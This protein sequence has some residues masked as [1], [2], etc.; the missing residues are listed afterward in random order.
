MKLTTADDAGGRAPRPRLTARAVR[1]ARLVT[2]G[3]VPRRAQVVALA[4]LTMT[5]VLTS[6]CGGSSEAST[7]QGRLLSVADLPAGWSAAPT[8][9]Q[10]VQTN[11]PC[12]SSL[13]TNPNGWTY[14][15]AGF[16][17]GTSIPTVGEVLAT[18][19]Q[20][21]QRW[22]SLDQALARCR[23]ATITIAGKKAEA[24]VQP[25]S[26]PRVASTSSAYAWAFT[27]AGIR[28]GFDF[29]LFTAGTYAGYLAYADLGPPT[30]ATVKAFVDAAV[31][32]AEKG[33]TTRVTGAVSIASAPVRAAHTKLGTV[34]YRII[35][36]GP[37]L[38]LITG[39]SG[40]MEGWDRRFVDSLAQH[41]RV[42]IFENAG[43]GGTQALPVP[44][45]VDAMA[46]QTSALI[47]T[48][49]LGRPDVLGW[50]MGSM[51]AQALAVLH[52][53]QVRRLVLCASYPGNGQAIR[54]SQE[55]IHALTSS[56]SQKVMADLFPAGQTAAQNT[57]L[58]A[59]SSY[60]TAPAAPAGTVTAQGNAVDQWWAGSD[61]AGQQT[62]EIAVPTLIADGT[63]DQLDPLANSHTLAGL[64]PG[65]K[66]AL[67]PD[68]G[69]AFL[70]QDQT[71]F[72]PLIES[73][74]G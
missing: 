49:G 37:P 73:F 6:G 22:Q 8:N 30:V 21:Q 45:S 59:I 41:Y 17:Q 70:F 69:H 24:T 7:L 26:F 1:P 36:N 34:A 67:Y 51:I 65:A 42:V 18:G 13:P 40:T 38:V 44:L 63:A 39:Y 74:L 43:V 55:A 50:S 16:V 23:T 33:S 2:T 32:K 5:A 71:A 11:A 46:N 31:A 12:L 61:P 68:A 25:L 72:V 20:A 54:P 52:P 29:V 15:I 9:P 47:D 27:I 4:V 64:I 66:L 48:L 60:P 35:G 56:D 3:R 14:A 58:A 19:P 57:Y 28:I 53:G 62:T 10:S